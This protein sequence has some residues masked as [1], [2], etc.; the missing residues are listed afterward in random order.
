MSSYFFIIE[1][2]GDTPAIVCKDGEVLCFDTE[3][4]ARD[5][6]GLCQNAKVIQAW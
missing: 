1:M 5:E 3:Q 6:A 2:V 4:E